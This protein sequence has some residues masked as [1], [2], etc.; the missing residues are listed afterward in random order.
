MSKHPAIGLV[1][2]LLT[3][4]SAIAGNPHVLVYTHNGLTDAGKPGFVH[5]NIAESAA[6]IRQLGQ[7]NGFEV[8]VSDDPAVFTDDHLKPYRVL[9][10]DN[11]NNKAFDTEEQKTAFQKFIHDGGGFV[12]IHS[13]CGSERKWPW[14]WQLIGG[15][16]KIHAKFQ[17]FTVKVMDK[18]H[19]STASYPA[20]T[21]T[22]ADEF[23][24]V[25]HMPDD[26]HILLAGDLAALNFPDKAKTRTEKYGD[27]HPLAWCHEFEGGRAWFTALGHDKKSYADPL[28]QKHILGGIQWAMGG[29]RQT[30]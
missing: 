18:Q 19:P 30:E 13:A 16:F 15:T 22:W 25:D 2:L 11:T 4:S 20:E 10:F 3:L 8:D 7:A 6:A 29:K 24:F 26:L 23:Y 5:D 9:V 21:F 14:F 17:P 12:G 28:F 27:W 1:L